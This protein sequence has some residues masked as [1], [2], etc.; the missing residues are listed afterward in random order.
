MKNI[1]KIIFLQTGMEDC[2]ES[3]DDFDELDVV[4]W[5]SDNVYSD[6]LE[7]ISVDFISAR[8]KELKQQRLL[9]SNSIEM[10]NELSIRIN[11]LKKYIYL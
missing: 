1:P 7:F 11:E 4:T 9:L 6:D 8:I 2:G 5:C 3:C 10:D